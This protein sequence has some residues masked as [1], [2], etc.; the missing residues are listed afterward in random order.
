M[1]SNTIQQAVLEMTDGVEGNTIQ[2]I[3]LLDF[4]TP[5]FDLYGQKGLLLLAV[6]LK[7]GDGGFHLLFEKIKSA[8]LYRSPASQ[9]FYTLVRGFRIERLQ[10]IEQCVTIRVHSSSVRYL[11]FDFK[12]YNALVLNEKGEIVFRFIKNKPEADFSHIR[13]I[14]EHL[15]ANGEKDTGWCEMVS[16][17]QS[18]ICIKKRKDTAS[19]GEFSLNRELSSQFFKKRSEALVQGALKII[20]SEQKKA[21]RLLEKLQLEA[22][23]LENSESIRV[24]GELLKYNLSKVQR[25]ISSV[26]LKDFKGNDVEIRLDP[27]R[28]PVE[29]MHR[30]FERYKKLG[31]KK[32]IFEKKFEYEAKRLS[33]LK[34]LLRHVSDK[35][36]ISL[37]TPPAEVIGLLKGEYFKESFRRRVENALMQR[38]DRRPLKKVEVKGEFLRF[39]SGTGKVIL[40]GKNARE[41]E[42]L[43]IRKARGNDLWFHIEDGTGSAVVLRYDRKGEFQETDIADAAALALYFSKL[44]GQGAGNVVYT[45]CK[46]VK[47]PRGTKPGYVIYHHNKTRYTVLEDEVL[48]RL[49]DSKIPIMVS[50][51]KDKLDI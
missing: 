27:A 23:E 26:S 14:A 13:L 48:A 8:Y 32:E 41:N 35:K 40:V 7:R 21:A 30:Y 47:K 38:H 46:Y 17:K 39:T 49:I 44:R 12:A 28:S 25:G 10:Y 11:V 34:S 6:S 24:C 16:G 36:T 33:A 3:R 51:Q 5:I 22:E 2:K 15:I 19:S 9:Q 4:C 1:K 43:A 31:R 50:G 45:H 18:D 42:E 37:N 20:K 29:N